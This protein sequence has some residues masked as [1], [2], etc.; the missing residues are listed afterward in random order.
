MLVVDDADDCYAVLGDTKSPKELAKTYEEVYGV[1]PTV[2]CQGSL[3]DLEKK[4]RQ[5]FQKEP[6]NVFAWM[7]LHYQYYMA[8]GATR[9]GKTENER[10]GD[11]RPQSVKEFMQSFPRDKLAMSYML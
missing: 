8:N 4:M 7:G 10:L 11:R 6:G 5:A 3:D 9:L 2:E 1:V